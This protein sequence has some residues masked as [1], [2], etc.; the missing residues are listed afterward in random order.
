[1]SSPADLMATG[2]LQSLPS[3]TWNKVSCLG[4]T[5]IVCEDSLGGNKEH[6]LEERNG[7]LGTPLCMLVGGEGGMDLTERTEWSENWR[8]VAKR[9]GAEGKGYKR[10]VVVQVRNYE[11][12]HLL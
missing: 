4:Q 8:G 9:E 3:R 12:L 1:M 10:G 7:D 6:S 5:C 2:E 11:R